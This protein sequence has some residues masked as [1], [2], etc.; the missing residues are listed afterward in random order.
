M[1]NFYELNNINLNKGG[2]KM[3][4]LFVMFIG[5]MVLTACAGKSGLKYDGVFVP[6]EFV[7]KFEPGAD[8]HTLRWMRPGYD[9][10]KYN[11]FMVDYVVFVLAPDSEYKGIN[12]DEMKKLADAASLALVNAIKE[13]YEV[14]SEPGPDVARVRFAISDLKQSSPTMSAI[15]SVVPVGLAISLVKKGTKDEWAG[16]GMTKGEVMILD[17]QSNLVI[18]AGY[19]DYSAQFSQRFTKWG[20]AE[21]AFKKWG[22]QIDKALTALKNGTFMPAKGK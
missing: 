19:G 13:K 4:K 12:A 3:K 2:R 18:A 14:V 20:S 1:T 6:K 11:K 10:A 15:T 7:E 16:G 5:L 21:D 9:F 17:S 8:E 22:E